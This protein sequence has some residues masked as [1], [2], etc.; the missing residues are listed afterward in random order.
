MLNL[1]TLATTTRKPQAM[2]T[3]TRTA[4]G[5]PR[6]R[7]SEATDGLRVAALPLCACPAATPSRKTLADVAKM[8]RV[9]DAVPNRPGNKNETTMKTTLTWDDHTNKV[10]RHLANWAASDRGWLFANDC[11]HSLGNYL[12]YGPDHYRSGHEFCKGQCECRLSQPGNIHA[13]RYPL[14]ASYLPHREYSTSLQHGPCE[15][16]Y[17]ETVEQAKAWIEAPFITAI[18]EILQEA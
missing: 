11:E 4:L 5:R 15:Y 2:T 14:L 6:K 13:V 10:K 18:V 7:R 3:R 9:A 17:F 16:R 1:W 12:D 8:R